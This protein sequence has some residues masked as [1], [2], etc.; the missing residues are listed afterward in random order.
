M[1]SEER[2]V[3]LEALVE[4]LVAE[5][6]ALAK[7][8]EELEARLAKNS[9]NSSMPPSGDDA[10]ARAERAKPASQRT[11]SRRKRGG[12][13]GRKG[14]T[15]VRVEDPDRVVVHR[16]SA[17]R[18][19]GAGLAD[20]PTVG[21][22]SRQVFDLIE[23][24][25][26]VTDHQAVEC[27]CSCGTTTTGEF[28]AE[29][30][31]PACWGPRTA[32]FAVYLVVRHHIPYKRAAEIL[33]SIGA[34][35]SV[36]WIVTQV[37]RA[38]LL[39]A[40]WLTTLRK[41]LIQARVV[42]ADE[43]SARVGGSLWWFHVASTALLTLLVA[44]RRRGK[45][46]ID[47]IGVLGEMTGTL[48]HDRA[49]MYWSYAGQ[50]H[51][52]C[53]AHLLRDLAGI[54]THPRHQPWALALRRVLLDA[55]AV[56]NTARARGDLNLGEDELDRINTAYHQ[57]LT[58]ALGVVDHPDADTRG[59]HRDAMNLAGAFFDYEPEILAFTR[60]LEIPPDNNM[61]ERDLR[62]AKIAQKITGGWRTPDG[63]DRFAAIRSYLETG[64]KHQQNPIELIRRLITT[65]PWQIPHPA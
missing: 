53:T 43:T 13:K 35:V 34:A 26:E 15:L 3:E 8:V 44:H 33:A 64:R 30:I 24:P 47:D 50:Q 1:T 14:H 54:A 51:G 42:H 6:L 60:N 18:G 17:C 11:K 2:I 65:G 27:E 58:H 63:V 36:G 62:M 56:C 9:T 10:K 21:V 39:L 31:G 52:L 19:C 48:I 45:A 59:I 16:P 5:N 32:A 57:A 23:R 29:A 49:A 22:K 7:R 40:G 41:R 46:A 38:A 25:V 37:A 4:T 12:Q 20:A 55:M 61:A 28:P